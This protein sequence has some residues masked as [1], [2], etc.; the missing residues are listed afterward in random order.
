[1]NPLDGAL[2]AAAH[3]VTLLVTSDMDGTLAPLVSTP[4]LA[5]PEPRA[6]RA[7]RRLAQLPRTHVCV[8]SGR[9]RGDLVRLFGE[10]GALRLVGSHGVETSDSASPVLSRDAAAHRDRLASELMAVAERY[11][12]CSV[13]VKPVAVAFHYR[14]ASED[15]ATKALN[16]ILASPTVE[17]AVHVMHGSKVLELGVVPLSKGRAMANLREALGASCTVFVGDDVTDEDAFAVL[18]EQDVGVKVG[19]GPSRAAYRIAGVDDVIVLLER[20]ATLREKALAPRDATPIDELSLLS[21]QRTCALVNGGGNIVWACL[22]RFDSAA[23]FA[24]LLGG[25]SAGHFSVRPEVAAP[26]ARVSYAG[27][28]MVLET[29]WPQITLRDYFDCGGG[30]AYQRAGR[31]D[32]VRSVEGRGRVAI[33]FAPRLDFGRIATRLRIHA[34][35]LEV[36]DS[37][38]PIVLYAPDVKWQIEEDGPH[39]T[40]RG[41]ATLTDAPLVLELRYGTNNLRPPPTPEA[42]RRETT[43][44]FWSMWAATLRVPPLAEKLIRRSALVLKGL[45]Y[46]PTGAIVAAGTSSLPETIGGVRNWDYRYCWV[47]DGAMSAAALVKLGN[48]GVGLK[49][50]DWLLNVLDT[51]Q[52]PERLSPLYTVTGHEL[53]PEAELG[54]LSGYRGSRPVRV[55]NAAARQVQL[56]VFGPVVELISE[57]SSAAAPVS[58]EHWRLVEAM[59]SAVQR[60]WREPDHGIWEVRGPRR[61]YVHSKVMCWL[62]LD[63]ACALAEHYLG[64]PRTDW[65]ALREEIRTDVLERG[66]NAATGA[67]TVAY[68]EPEVD[69]SALQVGLSGLLHPTDGRFVATAS[70]VEQTL[71]DGPTVFR[72]R[73]DDGLPGAEGGFHLCTT[74]LIES[75]VLLGRRSEAHDLLDAYLSLAGPTGLFSEEYC[76]QTRASLGNHPQ[77]YSH[78]GLINAAIALAGADGAGGVPGRE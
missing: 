56:D 58:P 64:R 38:D 40:A 54:H 27:D 34:N 3:A 21:D 6:V 17:D 44:R 14:M 66:W 37:L 70:A 2:D 4:D 32:L 42:K 15:D 57:L 76:P 43:E 8:L 7:L 46:G 1:M 35:G 63:R 10:G 62:T 45:C 75:L 49:F 26:P 60:R 65:L 28:S 11:R 12:G 29:R 25:P 22:P 59:V 48:T 24:E 53:G 67:F 52:S 13:E 31:T 23:L 61:H 30:R 47:R 16:E 73:M 74:W 20:L 39:Q 77:A 78:L 5:A 72:Y 71:R 41:V 51:C 55:G 33:T 19:P 36:E 50:L 69:A 9:S 68:G 18:G